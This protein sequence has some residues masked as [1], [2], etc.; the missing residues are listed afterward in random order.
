MGGDNGTSQAYAY[1]PQFLDKTKLTK[2]ISVHLRLL[3]FSLILLNLVADIFLL[4]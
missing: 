2:L 1:A 3:C 4:A